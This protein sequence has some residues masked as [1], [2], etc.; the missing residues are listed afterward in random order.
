MPRWIAFAL[1]VMLAWVGSGFQ[2]KKQEFKVG[3]AAIA[4]T[5]FGPNPDWDVGI[6][7]SG[8][9]HERFT[10]AHRNGHGDA[11]ERFKDDPGNTA[12]DESSRGKY[13]G[14]YLAGFGKNRIATAKHDDLWARSEERRVGKECRSR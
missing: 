12:L 4:L 5:P 6:T 11:G 13:D 14:I 10:A 7:E 2:A 9:W 3:A 1:A 8:V